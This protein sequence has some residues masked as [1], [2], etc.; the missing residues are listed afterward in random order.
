MFSVEWDD[1]PQFTAVPDVFITKY[2]PE[3]SGTEVKIFIYLL[4]ISY[5]TDKKT[6][7]ED[8][9]AVLHIDEDELNAALKYWENKKLLELHYRSGKVTGVKILLKASKQRESEHRLPPSRVKALMDNNKDAELLT[10]VA[11]QYC[12]RA[13]SSVEVGTLLYFLDELKFPLDL[14]QFLVE[15]CVSK[16]HTSIRYIEKVGLAWHKSGYKTVKEARENTTLWS[17]I[18]FEV[19]KAFGISG[20]NPLKKEI[21]FIDKWYNQY[22]FS[23]DIISEA[24]SI[25]VERT[26]K[27]NFKY[28]DGILKRW[29]EANLKTLKDIEEHEKEFHLKNKAS[30]AKP[31][32]NQFLNYKQRDDD[33]DELERI[34]DQQFIEIMEE[35]NGAD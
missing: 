25:T 34:L 6:K 11:E 3:A 16:G 12:S 19:L 17:K 5:S 20:R 31:K 23:L 32:T 29:H 4:M 21:E 2:M 35:E 24:C 18:H 10:Y 14:C 30:T 8:L 28:A 15:Y 27:Q 7:P 9:T 13:L 1:N 26:G 22:C 33:L